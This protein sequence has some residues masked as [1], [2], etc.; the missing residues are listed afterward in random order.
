MGN[1]RLS[2]I[3]PAIGVVVDDRR[4]VMSVVA[5]TAAGRRREVAVDARDCHDE[6]VDVVLRRMLEPWASGPGGKPRGRKPWVQVG[7]PEQQVFQAS[8]PISASNRVLSAQSLFLEA[9]QATNLRAEDHVFDLKKVDVAKLPL[10]IV[11]AC[12]REI[13]LNLVDALGRAGV[14]VASAEPAPS[15]LLRLALLEGR[16]SRGAKL[17]MR[18]FLGPRRALALMS[19]G[20]HPLF[21][22]VFELPPGAEEDAIRSAYSTLWLLWR[23][24]GVK[25]PIAAVHL[26]GRPGLALSAQREAFRK[27]AGAEVFRSS[28]PG[29]DAASIARGIAMADPLLEDV[30]LD[31]ARRYRPDVPIREIFPW[32]EACLQAVLIGGVS[33]LLCASAADVQTAFRHARS[34]SAEFSWMGDDDQAKLDAEQK[35]IEDQITYAKGFL[36]S[37]VAW[38]EQLRTIAADTPEGT[39]ITTLSG[40][41]DVEIEGAPSKR[42]GD[43]QLVVQFNTPLPEDGSIPPHIDRFLSTLREEP[44][45]LRHFPN[46]NVSGLQTGMLGKERKVAVYSVV[47]QPK[48]RSGPARGS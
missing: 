27:Q 12:R 32:T 43:K 34:Q 33:L 39:T 48:A 11:S 1:W 10:A 18:F 19:C 23:R 45:V 47:F 30:G 28:G 46:I 6:P 9:V 36:R 41:A 5:S 26:H 13:V 17:C 15:A 2:R 42:K 8:V 29:Y 24:H 40:D 4:V 25:V 31:L 20:P 35:G 16:G 3:R 21:W 38:T 7:L 22:Q 44:L 14:Q 37:R